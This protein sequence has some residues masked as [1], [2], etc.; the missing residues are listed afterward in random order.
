[1]DKKNLF[2]LGTILGPHKTNGEISVFIESDNPSF[3]KDVENILV[4]IN[5][6]LIPHTVEKIKIT[7][8]TAYVKLAEVNNID[9]AT[10]LTKCDVYLPL[11]QLPPLTGKHFYFHE[12]IGFEARD[13]H[14]GFFGIV[15]QVYDLPKQ[16]IISIDNNGKE[17]LVP[18]V[19]DFILSID[20]E[21]KQLHFDLPEGLL[22]VYL[23]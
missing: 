17:V 20:R 14:H 16:D 21:K 5:T 2:Q 4:E 9:E 1:M 18:V 13:A 10:A 15:K 8:D 6:M 19:D 3:Y 12:I 11:D 7:G 23:D 22:S